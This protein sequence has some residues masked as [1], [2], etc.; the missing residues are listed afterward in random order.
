MPPLITNTDYLTINTVPLATP[1]YFITN[2]EAIYDLDATRG[3]DVLIPGVA[4]VAAQRRR[5]TVL[6]VTFGLIINGR[7]NDD[8]TATADAQVGLWAHL[9]YLRANLG[10]A[11]GTGN[12]T[13]SATL[14]RTGAATDLTESI[15]VEALRGMRYIGKGTV[16]TTLDISIPSGAFT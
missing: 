16:R 15:H 7:V 5:I 9:D 8:G 11:N 13:V 14:T 2:L 10:F 3:K 6:D 4:G 12:G 1:A